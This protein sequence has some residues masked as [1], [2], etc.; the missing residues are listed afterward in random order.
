[1]RVLIA[2]ECS[3]TV[4]EAFNK[5]GHDAWSCD[6]KET[7]IPGNHIKS[8]VLSLL[9]EA[10]DMMIAFPPC[11]YLCK[12]QGHLCNNNPERLSKQKEAVEFIKK[13]YYSKIPYVAIENP[14]GALTRLFRPPEQLIHPYFF[15]DQYQKQ[16]SLWL[17][18]LPLLGY[19]LR[20][21]PRKLRTISNHCNSRMN[22]E[23][24][25]E[26]RSSWKYF[27][28]LADAM[29]QQWSCPWYR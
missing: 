15:G 25:S 20:V 5:L 29:A 23:T 21:K 19:C 18:G 6:L 17:K 28:R 1:L 9:N 24:K 11:T 26:I 2:C 14:P 8:D 22:Q 10:W 7:K 13:L 4:R 27:P 12:A 3:G 16:I